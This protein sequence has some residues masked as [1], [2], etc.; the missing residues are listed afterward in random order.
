MRAPSSPHSASPFFQRS[1]CAAANSPADFPARLAS[2]SLIQGAKSS[3]RRLGNVS[4]RFVRS[5]FGSMT[6]DGNPV[7]GGFFDRRN[8]EAGFPT[9]RHTDTERVG[10]EVLRVVKDQVRSDLFRADVVPATEVKHA[11]SFEVLHM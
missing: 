2:S 4:N 3:G 6:I 1:A 10:H 9:S 5:P 8:A 11:K 7:D